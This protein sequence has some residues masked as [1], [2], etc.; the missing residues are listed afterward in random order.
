MPC[1]EEAASSILQECPEIMPKL[2][3]SE[4]DEA[5]DGFSSK[6]SIAVCACLQCFGT[7]TGPMTLS[8]LA[9]AADLP[10]ANRAA[11]AVSRSRRGGYVAR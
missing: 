2:K 7:T 1:L 9:R 11:H 5:R 8:D 6:L 3:R 4:T 10:R